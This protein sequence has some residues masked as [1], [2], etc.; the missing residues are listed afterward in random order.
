MKQKINRKTFKPGFEGENCSGFGGFCCYC[1]FGW[2]FFRTERSSLIWIPSW[3]GY[4]SP[5]GEVVRIR[6]VSRPQEKHLFSEKAYF[7]FTQIYPLLT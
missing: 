4:F 7:F 2:L 1:R 6:E 3:A 5:S